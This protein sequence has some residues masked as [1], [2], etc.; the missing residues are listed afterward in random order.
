MF[1]TELH[2]H[3]N[4][5]SEC[6][7][8]DVN[9]IVEKYTKGGYSS[10]VLCNHFNAGTYKYLKC[11]SWNEWIDKYIYGYTR[12]KKAAQGKLNIMLGMELRFTGASNDYLVFGVTEE[13]LRAHEYLYDMNIWDFHKLAKENG[14]L[15]IQAHPF[16]DGMTVV[17]PHA[18]DGVEVFNGHMGHDSRNDI[19]NAWADKFGLIKTSGTDFHYE[20]VPTNAG[21]LTENEIT[22][23]SELVDVLKSGKYKLIKG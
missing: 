16:R 10:L 6:A 7:R 8:V 18:L 17:H 2:C 14:M 20:D 23:L 9:T 12:L 21:I 5:V 19:A 15:F 22:S 1:K 13:F 11:E 3:S 4:D